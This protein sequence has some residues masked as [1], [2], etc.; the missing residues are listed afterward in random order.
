MTSCY[1]SVLSLHYNLAFPVFPDAVNLSALLYFFPSVLAQAKKVFCLHLEYFALIY[2][3]SFFPQDGQLF[4]GEDYG[5]IHLQRLH[6]G[7]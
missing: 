7:C 3:V 5:F 2:C 1:Y 4:E 6:I